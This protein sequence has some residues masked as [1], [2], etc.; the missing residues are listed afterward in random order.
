MSA[1]VNLLKQQVK[2]VLPQGLFF[3]LFALGKDK[4]LLKSAME[5]KL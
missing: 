5:R 3:A 4:K 2:I 1:L